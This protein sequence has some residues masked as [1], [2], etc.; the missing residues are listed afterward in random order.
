MSKKVNPR[1]KQEVERIKSY[2]KEYKYF[3]IIDMENLPS[4]QLQKIRHQLKKSVLIIMF[5]KRLIKLALEQLKKEKQNLDAVLDSI[6][7][8][9]ALLFTNDDPFKICRLIEKSKS[10]ASAKPG[11]MAPHDII[12]PAGPTQFTPGPIIGELGQLGMKT[13]VKEGKVSLKEDKLLVKANDPISEKAA[14]LLSKLNIR[15]MEIGLNIVAM[16]EDGMVYKKDVLSIDDKK[17]LAD[18]MQI[19]SEATALAMEICYISNDTA[20]LLVSKAYMHANALAE[21]TNINGG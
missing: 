19:S 12:I 20:S 1:K 11:Q 21:K 14:S 15:P 10:S 4:A 7:G 3:G 17:L 13:E 5:K 6:E 18:I 9:P 2:L 8:L 16:Y